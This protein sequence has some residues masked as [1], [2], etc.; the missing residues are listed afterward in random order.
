MTIDKLAVA[1][2]HRIGAH[3]D[4]L[5]IGWVVRVGVIPV[6]RANPRAVGVLHQGAFIT[7]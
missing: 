6:A 2:S 5:A 4:A 7:V 3:I 1:H